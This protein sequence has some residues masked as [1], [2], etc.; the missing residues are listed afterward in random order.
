MLKSL[1]LRALQFGSDT[2]GSMS[3]ETVLIFPLLLWFYLSTFTYF[4]AY[5]TQGTNIKATYTIAD[6]ISREPDGIFPEHLDTMY[7]M[8]QFLNNSSHNARLRVTVFSRDT[9]NPDNFILGPTGWSC[10]RG[11]GSANFR[12]HNAASLNAMKSMIPPSPAPDQLIMVETFIDYAPPFFARLFDDETAEEGMIRKGNPD[13]IM[14]GLAPS[15]FSHREIL[16]P[17]SQSPQVPLMPNGNC[18]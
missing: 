4:D 10:T 12:K 3:V 14:I 13:G 17:R 11:S 16:R 6:A 18:T 7:T 9:D 8:M 5:R 1:R 2:S 15:T